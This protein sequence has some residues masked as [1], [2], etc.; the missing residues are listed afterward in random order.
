M[1]DASY[2][3][4]SSDTG[5]ALSG[6]FA[7]LPGV[8][9]AASQA[10]VSTSPSATYG[11][12]YALQQQQLQ[13]QRAYDLKLLAIQQGGTTNG[14]PALSK[15]NQTYIIYLVVAIMLLLLVREL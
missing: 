2:S 12:A 5:D 10:F 14:A 9:Q 4:G 15:I 8:A 3:D 6:L 13:D 1:S 7:A 11:A